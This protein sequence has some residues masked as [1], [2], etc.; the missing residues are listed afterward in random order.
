MM[1][2]FMKSRIWV[3]AV[4][5]LLATA[6]SATQATAQCNPAGDNPGVMIKFDADAFAYETAYTPA[7]F[8]SAVGSQLTVVGIVSIFCNP[9]SDLNPLDSNTEYTFIW[10]GL[11]SQGTVPSVKGTGM[12][13]TTNYLGGEFRIYAGSPRNAPIYGALPTITAPG[14]V[15]DL[16][17]DGTLILSG[18]M[19]DSLNV[20]FTRSSSGTFT[21]S[22]R[23]NYRCTG[24][25]LFNR[26]GDAINVMAG[27]WSP[28]PPPNSNPPQPLG[29]TVLPAGW[30]AHPNGK[31]DMP[32][33]VPARPSTWG[34]IKS[35]YR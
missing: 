33:S 9:F 27:L 25:T 16:F 15:P 21:S 29:S 26:V 20:Y 35:M 13:Y 17:G 3:A 8:T 6:L 23:A 7:T 19:T 14:I 34:K 10:D 32:A 5:G 4:M 11:V 22:F 18:V 1:E 24:G 2:V 12:K 30:S 31:W 28:V